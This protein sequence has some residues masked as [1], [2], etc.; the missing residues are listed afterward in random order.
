MQNGT[1]NTSANINKEALDASLFEVFKKP[2]QKPPLLPLYPLF[3][4]PFHEGKA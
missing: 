4:A 1:N 2:T 3:I